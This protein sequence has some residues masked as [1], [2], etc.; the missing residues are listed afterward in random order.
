MQKFH[1][2]S[3][4]AA[5]FGMLYSI[6]ASSK[7]E[8]NEIKK[9]LTYANE[10]GINSIDTAAV[11]GLSE[12]ILGNIGVKDWSITSK[13]SPVPETSQDIRLWVKNEV[14]RTLVNL[15]VDCLDTFLIHKPDQLNLSFGDEI[16]IGLEELKK[17]GLIKKHGVSL[18]NL[19]DINLYNKK[20][21]NFDVFQI[22]FNIV[23]KD[24]ID[25]GVAIDLKKEGKFIQTRSAF[26]QGL[27]LSKKHQMS[28]RFQKWSPFWDSYNEWLD[29][30]NITALQACINY[31]YFQENIDKVIIGVLNLN[32]LKE[33]LEN[34]SKPE[35]RI[36]DFIIDEKE[37]LLN[38]SN[39]MS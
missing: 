30:E 9:I 2:I 12:E 34:I 10:M 7:V 39:W 32:Q 27:L 8:I 1:K 20:S 29:K 6:G 3:I 4:G 36:P 22:P 24:L 23:D 35:Y 28:E 17:D 31:V 33:I 15:K 26:L 38:P 13:L 14:K 37:K 19:G 25:T 16:Y 5:Q 11:Y 21:Y 18:Y